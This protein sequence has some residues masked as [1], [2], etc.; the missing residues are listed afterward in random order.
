MLINY[1]KAN[2]GILNVALQQKVSK[3]M[4]AE[5][6]AHLTPRFISLVPGMNEISDSDWNKI[7]DDERIKTYRSRGEILLPFAE[8]IAPKKE[9]DPV[10]ELSAKEYGGMTAKEQ[11]EVIAECEQVS[12]LRKWKNGHKTKESVDSFLNDRIDRLAHPEKYTEEEA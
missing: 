11:E 3:G 10:K 2:A 4:S 5:R 12:L 7:K 6:L 1:K 8:E 9:G